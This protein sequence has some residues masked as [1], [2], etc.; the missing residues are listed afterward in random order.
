MSFLCSAYE[1][2]LSASVA[3]DAFSTSALC[4]HSTICV[5]CPCVVLHVPVCMLADACH[6]SYPVFQQVSCEQQVSCAIRVILFWPITLL[7]CAL[8]TNQVP[9]C[10][11][12]LWVSCMYCMHEP[13]S[14]GSLWCLPLL[15]F[16]LFLTVA[17]GC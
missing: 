1:F 7:F 14:S 8:D 2:T 13:D 10:L 12:F 16:S 6:A 11:D 5:H 15:L 4:L 9:G 3:L 17:S